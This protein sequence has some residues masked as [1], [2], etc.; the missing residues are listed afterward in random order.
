MP[1]SRTVQFSRSFV[2]SCVRLWN[3]LHESVF[4]VKVLVLLKLQ[5]IAFFYKVDCPLF[6]PFLQLFL[7][8]Y[9]F[10]RDQ[11]EH[12]GLPTYRLFAFIHVI[13]G[14]V[15]LGGVL[16][17]SYVCF[18]RHGFRNLRLATQSQLVPKL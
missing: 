16:V 7:F 12:R 14:L 4:G 3:G 13:F 1:K 17:G 2:L 10:S 18:F 11:R 6:L 9:S 15:F 8:H 5:S